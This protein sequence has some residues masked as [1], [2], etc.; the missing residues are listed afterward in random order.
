M[1]FYLDNKSLV[2]AD[3]A[4]DHCA[5]VEKNLERHARLPL[6]LPRYL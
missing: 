4:V 5:L 1:V 6:H 3:V 2:I